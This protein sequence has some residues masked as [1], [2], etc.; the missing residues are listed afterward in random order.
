M[1]TVNLSDVIFDA[2][3]YPRD[4]W[5]TNTVEVYADSLKAGAEFPP[6]ILEKDTERILDGVHRWKAHLLY[7][8][9]YMDRP[10]VLDG[11]TD[12]WAKFSD[13]IE[14]EYH[15]VPDGVPTKLYAASLSAK[16]GDRVTS[17]EMEKLAREIFEDNPS[18]SLA[19]L[20][21]Y[22]PRSKSTIHR[23]V[24]DLI[25]R[26][27][28]EEIVTA[29]RLH[30]LGWTQQEI[31]DSVGVSQQ[32]YAKD[33]LQLFPPKVKVVKNLLS[34][35]HPHMDVAERQ[36]MPLQLVWAID[37][38]GRKDTTKMEYLK[39]PVQPY[40]VW[41]FGQCHTL[42]GSSHPGRIPGQLVAQVLYFYT[43]P[44]DVVVDPMGGSGT[45]NDVALAM[46][47]KCY[48]FDIDGRHERNDIIIHNI[49]KK[50]WH[51]RVKKADLIFW[52]PPYFEKMDSDNI[53]ETGYIEGSIS[54]K[55]R[56][57]YLEFFAARLKEAK[58]LVKKGATLAF[59]MSDWDD[60]TGQRE[61][62]FI[63]DYADLIT[64]AGWKL[65]RHIQVPLSTQQVHPDIVNKFRTSKRLA[66]LERYLL[67]AEA[68]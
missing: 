54:K 8:Q 52:D 37:L 67:I 2:T 63:W 13:T 58:E 15:T 39:I 32:N 31:A 46:G 25:A 7:R 48:S 35:G 16:H 11:K 10:S 26:R 66:R 65:K 45:T 20:A 30:R 27:K 19:E 24:A 23:Y 51:N 57:G 9:M 38:D 22:L 40:D 34:E 33:F 55:G 18:Y 49:D 1:I 28:E 21:K 4:K 53:G 17:S 50:G 43:S 47:R 14:V 29:Y 64:Q 60:E 56:E 62:I 44:G 59:L 12:Q 3:I 68:K 41:T 6:I 61:G 36:N 42:F 5:R